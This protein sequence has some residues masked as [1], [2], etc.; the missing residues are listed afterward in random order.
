MLK[1]IFGLRQV[2]TRFP[3]AVALASFFLTQLPQFAFAG[4]PLSACNGLFPALGTVTVCSCDTATGNL[5]VEGV[6]GRDMQPNSALCTPGSSSPDA[7]ID[8]ALASLSAEDRAD[9]RARAAQFV[10]DLRLDG[11]PAGEIPSVDDAERSIAGTI[12]GLADLIGG[13]FGNVR[14]EIRSGNFFGSPERMSPAVFN[15]I[16]HAVQDTGN[17]SPY[18]HSIVPVTQDHGGQATAVV[19]EQGWRF[20]SSARASYTRDETSPQTLTLSTASLNIGGF[21]GISERVGLAFSASLSGSRGHASGTSDDHQATSIG[22][23]AGLPVRLSEG[24]HFA[25]IASYRRG[26]VSVEE[27]IAGNKTTADMNTHTFSLG[28]VANRRWTW[29]D[30]DGQALYFL[31]PQATVLQSWQHVGSYR[32]SDGQLF[33][34]QTNS[35]GEIN[36]SLTAGALLPT[37]WVSITAVQPS[38]QLEA[39]YVHGEGS[40][41]GLEGGATARLRFFTRSPLSG[42]VSLGYRAGN[43]R[44]TAFARAALR[45]PLQP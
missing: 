18:S 40:A 4:L 41:N 9:F 35:S 6:H 32:R 33:A 16:E 44:R 5:F 39:G 25:P 24:V 12:I 11:V 23:T 31:E 21:H 37:D 3:L 43:E 34:S 38:L 30:R 28:A 36:L 20:S 13:G 7:R 27:T 19:R 26:W 45:V 17:P 22:I 8:A 29:P 14:R 1:R 10:E 15:A 2:I 42:D